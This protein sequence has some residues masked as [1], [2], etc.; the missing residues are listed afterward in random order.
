MLITYI[1]CRQKLCK[2]ALRYQAE[3]YTWVLDLK[4]WIEHVRRD[5]TRNGFR[6]TNSCF[7]CTP[8]L[9]FVAGR[10]RQQNGVKPSK[11]WVLDWKKWNGHIC[12]KKTRNSSRGINSCII[13]ASIT[14]FATCQ[15]RLRNGMEQPKTWVLDWNSGL[16]MFVATKQ[17]MVLEA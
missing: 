10:E 11:T 5:Q 2:S 12:C 9:I 4:L 6:G 8:I 13:C 16:G 7:K 1:N 3:L 17:E 14:V 15:V